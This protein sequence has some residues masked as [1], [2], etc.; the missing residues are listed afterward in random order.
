M[1]DPAQA[2][3]LSLRGRQRRGLLDPA[4]TAVLTTVD[5][6]WNL[7][8]ADHAWRQQLARYGLFLRRNN[9]APRTTGSR[10]EVALFRWVA[11]QRDLRATGHLPAD[12]VELL[13]RVPGHEWATDFDAAWR[14][15]FGTLQ[16]FI[17][18]EGHSRVPVHHR[19]GTMRLG[20]WAR[21][22][23]AQYATGRLHP[24]RIA[25]LEQLPHWAWDV[26]ATAWAEGI[27]AL[28]SFIVREGHARVR[29][30]VVENG[31]ALG[32]WVAARRREYR[33]G[34]LSDDRAHELTTKPGWVWDVQNGSAAST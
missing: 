1:S 11:R 32:N 4:I 23:R 33:S 9:R 5:P 15:G 14:R 3:L 24:D 22:R 16:K 2:S 34:R 27:A 21:E 8:G 7:S 18:R 29:R 6:N 26:Y 31:F 19:E 10:S 30:S 13:D 25:A 17:E 12:R 28:D 20:L